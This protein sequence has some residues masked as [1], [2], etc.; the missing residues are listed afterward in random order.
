MSG[1]IN[2]RHTLIFLP[3]LLSPFLISAF[4]FASAFMVLVTRGITRRPCGVGR[5]SCFT[6]TTL[7]FPGPFLTGMAASSFSFAS[8]FWSQEQKKKKLTQR[9]KFENCQTETWIC[10]EHEQIPPIPQ[11][12]LQGLPSTDQLD[13]F[14]SECSAH[15]AEEKQFSQDRLSRFNGKIWF[16]ETEQNITPLHP[17]VCTVHLS[18]LWSGTTWACSAGSCSLAH[19]WSPSPSLHLLPPPPPSLHHPSPP[20]FKST[21]TDL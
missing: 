13:S 15:S 21:A 7:P 14:S 12:K 10:W 18:S 11:R 20:R 8:Y 6:L 5:V 9:E 1:L 16:M 19:W 4:L 3:L 17:S 2:T